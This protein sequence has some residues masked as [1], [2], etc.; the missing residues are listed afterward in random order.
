MQTPAGKEC[1]YFYGDYYRG[2][3]QEECRLL[4]AASLTWKP[5][6]CQTCP[7]PEILMANACPHLILNPQLERVFPFVKQRVKI[8]S[9]CTKTTRANFDPHI[10]C[11]DC[12]PLP[13]IFDEAHS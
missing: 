5:E 12:H 7:V 9:Y 10:G 13:A 11:G 8:K 3:N 1:R 6:Y 4:E 2:R